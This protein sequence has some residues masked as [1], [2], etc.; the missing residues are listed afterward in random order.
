[1]TNPTHSS[2]TRQCI[3]VPTEDGR[4]AYVEF[5]RRRPGV[6][7]VDI[8]DDLIATAPQGLVAVLTLAVTSMALHCELAPRIAE[9]DDRE[10]FDPAD[11]D[12][13]FGSPLD[14]LPP[15]DVGSTP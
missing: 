1:M 5:E 11:M 3:E 7:S 9:M 13:T 2:E 14:T 12:A 15:P 6:W 10:E 4:R 8:S